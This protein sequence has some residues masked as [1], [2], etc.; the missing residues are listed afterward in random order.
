[1]RG[2][3]RG[4]GTADEPDRLFSAGFFVMCAFNFTVFLS[5]FQLCPTAPFRIRD[6]GGDSFTAGLFL[7]FLTYS[8]ALSAPFT[9]AMADRLGKRRML[10][11][12]SLVI[13]VLS[14]GY[15]ASTTYQVP[16]ALAVVHGLFWSG[17]L[18]S[19]AAYMTGLI[20]EARRAEGFGYWGIA[21][22]LA[23]AVAPSLG[24][25]LYRRGW[26]WLCASTGLLNL[27]MAIIAARLK[28]ASPPAHKP[29]GPLVLRE[30]IEWRVL[31]VSLTLFLYSFGYGGITSF[32]AFFAH[33]RGI[34]PPGI[35]FSAFAVV[36]IATRPFIA[37]FADR[38]GYRRILVPSLAFI[39][40]GLAL[41]ARAQT[42]SALIGSAVVFGIGFGSAYPV[43]VAHLLG[44]V[45]ESRRGAAFGG[46]LA[47]FDTG[48]GTGSIA[49]GFIAGR[50]GFPAA[51]AF[52]AG[53]SALAI[54]YF[55]VVEGRILPPTRR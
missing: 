35:Y 1:M 26:I 43:F 17:L 39:S 36:M 45:A 55:L 4:T 14:V 46:I 19:S 31:L 25:W 51:F 50:A 53:L 49:T 11:V 40:M 21:T 37:R 52:A 10:I 22:I 33:A 20:P 6:L 44:R 27:G 54:P 24:L 30:L 23:T 48:I 7:G 13:T 15:A 28:E 34:S 42:R 5:A 9:G 2:E 12:C 38:V 18:S 3:P 47:A 41:L 16:L 8:S 29:R 32:A